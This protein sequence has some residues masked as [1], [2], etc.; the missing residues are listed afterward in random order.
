M[1]NGMLTAEAKNS[2]EIQDKVCKTHAGGIGHSRVCDFAPQV[3]CQW[4]M[5]DC[6]ANLQP[7]CLE[8]ICGQQGTLHCMENS[9]FAPF[10]MHISGQILCFNSKD[11]VYGTTRVNFT[12]KQ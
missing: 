12:A 10:R 3:P 6:L 9:T 8:E 11:R 4:H 7:Q 2:L 5:V 1:A